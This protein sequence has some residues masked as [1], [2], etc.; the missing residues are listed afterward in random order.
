MSLLS[1]YKTGLYIEAILFVILGCLAISGPQFFTLA[2]ELLVGALFIAS[3]II[4][5]IRLIQNRETTSF[6]THLFVALFNIALGA[7]L[8]FFPLAGIISLTYLLIAYFFVDG[9]SKLYYAFELR[10][11]P[12]WGWIFISGLLSLA[13]GILI[14]TGLPGTAFWT[15][16]LLI[17]INML[18]FGLALFCLAYNLPK[19][20]I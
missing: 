4:Q 10:N 2:F 11:F 13:L 20:I 19:R 14:L 17:G 16:G 6:W 3:G 12:K 5:C 15:L 8:L 1:A 18:F 7:L 9:I